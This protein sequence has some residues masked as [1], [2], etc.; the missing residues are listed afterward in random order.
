[1]CPTPLPLNSFLPVKPEVHIGAVGLQRLGSELLGEG[2]TVRVRASGYSMFPAIRPGDV[3]EIE[4]VAGAGA[5][6]VPGTVVALRR[7]GDFVVHR[8]VGVFER[9]GRQWVFTRGD[10]VLRADEPVPVEEVAGTVI[11][12]I[13]GSRIVRNPL[14]RTNVHY[15]WNRLMV[16]VYEGVK[17]V[18]GIDG[19]KGV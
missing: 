19:I 15:R 14:P 10:S 4:P 6:L 3:I 12:I 17:G 11:T 9:E 2:L 7:E 8:L 18:K 13:R 16:M 5:G 1:M